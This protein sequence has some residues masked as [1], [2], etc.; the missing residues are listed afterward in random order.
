MSNPS[1]AGIS[2]TTHAP[3]GGR[4]AR[5]HQRGNQGVDS[6]IG[7]EEPSR[8]FRGEPLALAFAG[9]S[10]LILSSVFFRRWV[11]RCCRAAVTYG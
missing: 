8:D 4:G 10:Q 1:T 11:Y 6:R 2:Q 3:I 7:T 5:H 9:A